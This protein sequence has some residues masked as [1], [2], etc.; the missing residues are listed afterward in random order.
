MVA[1]TEL[2][3]WW[4]KLLASWIHGSDNLNESILLSTKT[5]Q[6]KMLTFSITTLMEQ[7][8]YHDSGIQ[9]ICNKGNVVRLVVELFV[10]TSLILSAAYKRESL[11]N[12]VSPSAPQPYST[13]EQF[14]NDSYNIFA[15][16]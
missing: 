13:I 5:L 14:V 12:I 1:E 16:P 6:S 8:Y 10:L 11:T 3:Q 9:E 7:S 2:F 15:Q 4:N